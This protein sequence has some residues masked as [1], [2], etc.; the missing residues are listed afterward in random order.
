MITV[1][2]IITPDSGS[3]GS[4]IYDV[5]NVGGGE[6]RGSTKFCHL[7]MGDRGAV[8]VLHFADTS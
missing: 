3:K 8:K 6:R 4:F 2:Y 7:L 1:I 5:S